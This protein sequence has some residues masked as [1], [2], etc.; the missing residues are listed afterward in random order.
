MLRSTRIQ[1]IVSFA[2]KPLLCALFVSLI[3]HWSN[4]FHSSPRKAPKSHPLLSKSLIVASTTSSNLTWLTPA[5]HNTHWDS[6][7]YTTDDSTAPLTV[8][9]NKGN[10][11]MA[12]LTYIIDHYHHLPDVM[13]FHHDHNQAWHQLFSSSYELSHLN[14][15]TVLKQGYVS[16]RCLSGCENIIE[17]LGNVAP[18]DDLK[19]AARDVQISSVLR[20]FLPG[21]GSARE[22]CGA[23]LCAVCG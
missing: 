13:F 22:D 15:E 19:G 5:L 18:L 6:K 11:A 1:R 14:P 17:L 4:I 23:V 2:A 3:L 21:G 9:V 7:V 16:S 12:Y 8:P 20:E 10:E